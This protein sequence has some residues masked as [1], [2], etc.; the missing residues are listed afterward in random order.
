MGNT[1]IEKY[2]R[3]KTMDQSIRMTPPSLHKTDTRRVSTTDTQSVWTTPP[4][5]EETDTIDRSEV[6]SF[7]DSPSVKERLF[8]HSSPSSTSKMTNHSQ[9]TDSDSDSDS[10]LEDSSSFATL[11]DSVDDSDGA[12]PIEHVKTINKYE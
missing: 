3:F 7:F 8:L 4:S 5:L 10:D 11:D 1:A 9:S 2:T 6:A 12:M